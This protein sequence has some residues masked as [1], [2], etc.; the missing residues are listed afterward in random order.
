[1]ITRGTKMHIFILLMGL[2]AVA[3]IS[4]SRG[5]L[6]VIC[7]LLKECFE[8]SAVMMENK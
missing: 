2:V 3:I 5:K 4:G 8:P 6:L 7:C 1:M